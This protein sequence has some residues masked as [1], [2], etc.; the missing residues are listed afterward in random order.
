MRFQDVCRKAPTLL[1]VKHSL[2]AS[3]PLSPPLS[4]VQAG[5]TYRVR[6]AHS[7]PGPRQ[8]ID[9]P[10]N[11]RG[12]V[13]AGSSLR[14]MRPRVPSSPAEPSATSVRSSLRFDVRSSAPL[15]QPNTSCNTACAQGQR[16]ARYGSR[17]CASLSMTSLG[18]IW[19]KGQST[20]PIS[21][22]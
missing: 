18:K 6:S 15:R 14:I 17:C 3:D 10:L 12:V 2:P 8:E 7:Q 1:A 11:A 9:A 13:E 20:D 5:P 16:L 4:H 19:W 21:R 22:L